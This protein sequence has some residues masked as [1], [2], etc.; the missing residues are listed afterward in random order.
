MAESNL[1]S[2]RMLSTPCSTVR[3][4]GARRAWEVFGDGEDGELRVS[5]VLGLK[6]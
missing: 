4:R 3:Y 6:G 2:A 5:S 1:G